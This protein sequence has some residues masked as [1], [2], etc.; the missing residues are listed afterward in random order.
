MGA[1]HAAAGSVL[2]RMKQTL[3]WEQVG[4][5]LRS[6]VSNPRAFPVRGAEPLKPLELR[7]VEQ[8]GGKIG[9]GE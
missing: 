9:G 3:L 6:I 5:K 8:N 4:S 7:G 1:R 2:C